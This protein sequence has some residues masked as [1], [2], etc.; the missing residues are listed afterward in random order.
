MNKHRG[1]DRQDKRNFW[2]LILLLTMAAGVGM[3]LV[4]LDA[5]REVG[6]AIVYDKPVQTTEI[7]EA[8]P[9]P[10]LAAVEPSDMPKPWVIIPAAKV[11]IPHKKQKRYA[12]HRQY[13]YVIIDNTKY[14]PMQK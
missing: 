8:I 2:G 10:S 7:T 3:L 4:S 6:G 13:E 1:P 9:A 5:P 11:S 14:Y 12:R